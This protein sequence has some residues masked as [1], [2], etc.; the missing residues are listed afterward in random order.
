MEA[1]IITEQ[2][3]IAAL[4]VGQFKK[5]FNDI[6]TAISPQPVGDDIPDIFG[7][8]VCVK[9]TGYS[10]NSINKFVSERKIPYYKNFG[11]VLFRKDEI[12]TWLLS[13]RVETTA[14]FCDRKDEELLTRTGK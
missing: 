13:G 9:V 4:T 8:D 10:L 6:A 2:T 5:L 12:R 7:K 14:E 1:F 3:P 11:K